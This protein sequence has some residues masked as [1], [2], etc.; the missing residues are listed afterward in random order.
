MPVIFKAFVVLADELQEQ[1]QVKQRV[2]CV[3][4]TYQQTGD[5]AS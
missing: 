2:W 5:G 1:L 3:Q 4:A